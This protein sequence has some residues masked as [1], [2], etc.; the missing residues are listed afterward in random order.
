[1]KL[2]HNIRIFSRKIFSELEMLTRLILIISVLT[3]FLLT[4]F[5][6]SSR[7]KFDSSKSLAAAKN[8]RV[9][10]VDIDDYLKS[11][12]EDVAYGRITE[13]RQKLNII[14][15]FEPD[16]KYAFQIFNNLF[17]E[18]DD[19]EKQISRTLTI[20]NIQPNWKDA[21]VRLADLYEKAG[22]PKLATEARERARGLKTS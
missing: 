8:I 11:A 6:E 21:W 10:G 14:L 13:A 12:S 7:L 18:S 20:I 19:I 2:T 9:Q 16:N 5:F 4:V 3:I 15:E 17:G 22:N 1:M